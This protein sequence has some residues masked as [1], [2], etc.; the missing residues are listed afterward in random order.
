MAIY[1]SLS[2]KRIAELLSGAKNLAQ[3]KTLGGLKSDVTSNYNEKKR[4]KLL[5]D[6]AFGPL[7]RCF[8]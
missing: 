2:Q 1:T 4:K 7:F 3:I 6:A 5:S 8:Y